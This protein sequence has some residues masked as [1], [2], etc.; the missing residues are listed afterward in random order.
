MQNTFT[1]TPSGRVIWREREKEGGERVM[2]TDKIPQT[3]AKRVT[4]RQPAK[5]FFILFTLLL[6]PPAAAVEETSPRSVNNS[7]MSRILSKS[8]RN[9]ISAVPLK[10]MLNTTPVRAAPWD[11]APPCHTSSECVIIKQAVMPAH[12][13]LMKLTN[14]LIAHRILHSGRVKNIFSSFVSWN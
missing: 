13:G 6:K 7:I 14:S 4:N 3:P 1:A 2:A 10:Y 8:T 9:V 11:S 12:T 5:Q